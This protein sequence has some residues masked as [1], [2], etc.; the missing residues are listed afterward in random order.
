MEYQYIVQAVG[1]SAVIFAL[2]VYQSNNRQYMLALATVAACLFASHY[3][4]LG[5][6]TGAVMNLIG[7]ARSFVF[8]HVKP[9]KSNRWVLYLFL[10][11]A[12]VA[13]AATWHGPISLLAL[14]G[15]GCSAVASW[16]RNP[17]LIRR[18]ALATPFPWFVY[19]IL[20]GSIAGMVVEM[21]SLT[22]NL[23]G[24]HRHDSG[25]RFQ[26]RLVMKMWRHA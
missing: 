12:I 25:R 14:A 6:M 9:R 3:F 16:Q 22:S 13:T 1:F 21:M 11:A 8:M 20:T 26:L 17:R 4:L 23:I 5:A 15:T 2:V 24:R 18:F 10:G 7:A 19:A